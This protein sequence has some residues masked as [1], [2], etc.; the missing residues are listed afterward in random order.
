MRSGCN[1]I[2]SNYRAI[3]EMIEHKKTGFLLE[4]ISAKEI[5]EYIFYCVNNKDVFT[6]ISKNAMSYYNVNFTEEIHGK[7]MLALIQEY[8]HSK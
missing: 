3:P 8:S 7:K 2:A 4:D 5:A 1:V 6:T